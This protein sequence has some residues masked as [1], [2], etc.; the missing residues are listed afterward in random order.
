MTDK[1]TP[2]APRRF[3]RQPETPEAETADAP[4]TTAPAP[5][6]NKQDLVVALLRRPQGAT[7]AEMIEPTS[8]LP[9]S[10]RAVLTGLRKKGHAIEKTK[11]DEVTCYRIVEAA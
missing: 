3:A 11:R 6:P 9:H 2:K 10:T 7:L 5:K 4:A 8:W 1:K